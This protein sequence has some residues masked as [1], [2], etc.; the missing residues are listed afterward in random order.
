MKY[1]I[2]LIKMDFQMYTLMKNKEVQKSL[3]G[4]YPF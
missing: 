2:L 1:Y 4:Q 3:L